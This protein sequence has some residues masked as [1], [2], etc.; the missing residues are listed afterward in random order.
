MAMSAHEVVRFLRTHY[1]D[2]ASEPGLLG[3]GEWSQAYAFALDGRALV[4]RVGAHPQDFAKDEVMSAVASP[5]LPIPAILER[6]ECAAGHFAVSER[7]YGAFLDDLDEQGMRAVLPALFAAL[8]AVR[9]IDTSG[10]AGYG[11]WSPAGVAPYASWQEALLS[12]GDGP[13]NPRTP[14]WR[15]AL[16]SSATGSGPFNTAFAALKHMAR[17]MPL[18]RHIIHSDLLNRNVLVDGSRVTAV[19]DWGNAMYGDAL[20]DAAWFLYWWPWFPAWSR[21]DMG[22]EFMR[23]WRA[24]S[25][26]PH[27]WRDRLLCYQLHI[28]LEAQAY[29]A[30]KARWT[31]LEY[32]A[33]RTLELL[34]GRT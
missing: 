4:I 17:E 34:H 22:A 6:G 23:H 11:L 5:A 19:L 30:F 13:E 26:V 32:T 21:I 33:R 24:S 1:G 28:G 8:D 12:V 29:N 7:G 31:E 16:H 3:N 9:T 2:R 27:R 18:G 15:A 10:T 20:Y 14:G 25:S